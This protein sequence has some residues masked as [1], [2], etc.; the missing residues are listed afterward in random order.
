MKL[1]CH[2]TGGGA[3][4]RVVCSSESVCC[5]EEDAINEVI[6]TYLWLRVGVYVCNISCEARTGFQVTPDGVD[7]P[8]GTSWQ[9]SSAPMHAG[10]DSVTVMKD[11]T[12]VAT[13]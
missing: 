12:T 5:D 11:Q 1:T 10:K 6:E 3:S 7:T 13:P 8:A 4:R 9:F 2:L